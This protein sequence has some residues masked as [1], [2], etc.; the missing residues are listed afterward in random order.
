MEDS[1]L[2]KEKKV[3]YG[4]FW[5]LETGAAWQEYREYKGSYERNEEGD[6]GEQNITN[7]QD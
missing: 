7:G 6:E 5:E 2:D 4:W 3:A 1:G